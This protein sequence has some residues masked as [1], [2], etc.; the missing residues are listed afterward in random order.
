VNGPSLAVRPGH[1]DEL[2]VVWFTAAAA[3]PRVLAAFSR[4]GGASFDEPILLDADEPLGRVDVAWDGNGG[5]MVL[6]LSPRGEEGEADLLL[7][8]LVPEGPAGKTFQVAA[9][10]TARSSGF[11]RLVRRDDEIFLVWTL[12][13]GDS[14]RLQ[15]GSLPLSSLPGWS[16]PPVAALPGRAKPQA[17]AAA[18]GQDARP[19]D[20]KPGSRV[21][22]YS[23][24]DLE[25]E[26][27]ELAN[28]RGQ[29]LLVNFWATWCLPCRQET[30]ALIAIHDRYAPAGL[31][32]VGISVDT[33]NDVD[34][35]R[36]FLAA[37]SVPYRTLLDPQDRATRAFG[38]PMLPGSFL[39]NEDGVLVW[40]R[41]G[42]VTP[43][44]A[45]LT[46]ALDNL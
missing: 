41:F 44:D 2:V 21:P 15:A 4:D 10:S 3:S 8:R 27:I 1:E 25:G 24:L 26:R 37:E 13:Q 35:V 28:L 12:P 6:W 5:V 34:K 17:P 18:T 30:P 45:E 46:A 32:V 39:F 38:L 9:T 16:A 36:R 14:T 23:A 19:W 20:G 11:P 43:G 33:A 22:E 29:P 7:H 31:Q 42:I 40:S